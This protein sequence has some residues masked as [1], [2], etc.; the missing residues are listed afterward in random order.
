M[1]KSQLLRFAACRSMGHEWHH[2]KP[3]GVDDESPF[4]APFG[5]TTG[6]VGI[7]S[8]CTQCGTERMRW[9]TRS[10]ESLMRYLH[11]D[12]YSTHGEERL[13]AMEWRK[14]YVATIFETFE[15]K[16]TRKKA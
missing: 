16:P 7:P 5:G 13:T 11:P 6:M 3:I 9:V 2:Q 14:N 10:G 4:R 12:G 15:R 8:T 1:R